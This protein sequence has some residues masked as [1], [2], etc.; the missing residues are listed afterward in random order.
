MVGLTPRD[1]EGWTP[2]IQGYHKDNEGWAQSDV[3]G[4]FTE[5][6]ASLFARSISD[7]IGWDSV[8][9]LHVKVAVHR[10][11]QD[12]VAAVTAPFY[13]RTNGKND[14]SGRFISKRYVQLSPINYHAN[15]CQ[16]Y[17]ETF[18]RGASADTGKTEQEQRRPTIEPP[19]EDGE[20]VF[21]VGIM[22][23]SGGMAEGAL[24]KATWDEAHDDYDAVC[25]L[26]E[27]VNEAFPEGSFDE[28]SRFCEVGLEQSRFRIQLPRQPLDSD[29]WK[30]SGVV[31][32]VQKI[33]E[34]V[35]PVY[36][37]IANRRYR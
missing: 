4:M 18:F 10:K 12:P 27:A 30:A 23:G 9:V 22:G 5:W 21:F 7:F 16:F 25:A 15:S 32:A 14:Q 26:I 13:V 3:Y 34:L 28:V 8:P 36:C 33:G 2:D 1:I 19:V 17:I 37:D 11:V 20:I 29:Y 35:L 31:E 24:D 6:Q